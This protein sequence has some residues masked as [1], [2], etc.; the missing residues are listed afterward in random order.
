VSFRR[1]A[2]LGGLVVLAAGCGERLAT[3]ADCPALCPGTGAD[4]FDTVLVAIPGADSTYEG[5]A[6]QADVP[7]ILVSNG[8]PEREA[9]AFLRFPARPDTITVAGA[10]HPYT[11]DSEVFG[12]ALE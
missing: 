3:P 11:T 10:V 12:F 7:S 5:Y 9:R 2:L 4:I 6:S 1:T 8:L